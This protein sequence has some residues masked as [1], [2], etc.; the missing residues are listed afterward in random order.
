MLRLAIGTVL[1]F[2]TS[3]SRAEE[4]GRKG[5]LSPFGGVAFQHMTQNGTDFTHLTI[6]P[7]AFYF[8]A[9]R[10]ALGLQAS[11]GYDSPGVENGFRIGHTNTWGLAPAVA[12][13]VPLGERLS[14]FP[15]AAVDFAWSVYSTTGTDHAMA[16]NVFAPLLFIPVPH[17]FLGLG[18][19][20]LWTF[21]GVNSGRVIIGLSGG[22]GGWF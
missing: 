2:A 16:A 21:D 12:V 8:V 3:A 7:G 15:Q 13:A 9:D 5:Q 22:V 11:A 20:L 19:E 1:L 6:R 4:F 10:F 18:P 17:F 14:L